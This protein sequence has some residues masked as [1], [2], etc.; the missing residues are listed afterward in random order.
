MD[1]LKLINELKTE[2]QRLDMAIAALT[3][4]ATGA[5]RKRGRPP[6]WMS[7][8]QQGKSNGQKAAA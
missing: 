2:R 7:E 1:Y 5:K 6:A 3:V 4:I 8:A